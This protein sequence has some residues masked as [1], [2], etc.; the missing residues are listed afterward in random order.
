MKMYHNVA[1]YKVTC[2]SAIPGETEQ[3]LHFAFDRD[4]MSNEDMKIYLD[5]IIAKYGHDMILKHK[6]IMT[7]RLA[8]S[9]LDMSNYEIIPANMVE[10][11]GKFKAPMITKS[12]NNFV[13][14]DGVFVNIPTKMPNKITEGM[15]LQ[16]V[17]LH[18]TWVWD[19]VFIFDA[20]Y[21]IGCTMIDSEDLF[22]HSLANELVERPVENASYEEY[23]VGKQT[24]NILKV[25][26]KR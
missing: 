6:D 9:I 17:L 26:L 8:S 1:I 3:E 10:E 16:E 12:F 25:D 4:T 14:E 23:Q 20:G 11:Y 15:T 18:H 19:M 5:C 21:Y 24:I 22:I 2:N 7:E 13:V